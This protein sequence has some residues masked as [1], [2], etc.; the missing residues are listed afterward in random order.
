MHRNTYATLE[1]DKRMR[2]VVA[3][4]VSRRHLYVDP[5]LS[6]TTSPVGRCNRDLIA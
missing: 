1:F 3:F 6:V 5:A 2:Y 4:Q